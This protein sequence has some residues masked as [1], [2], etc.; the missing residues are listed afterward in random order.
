MVTNKQL[1]A[2][3]ENARKGGPKTVEGKAV[4]SRNAL[5]HGLTGRDL[6]IGNEKLA[7]VERFRKSFYDD[8]SPQGAVETMYVDI[9]WSS[10]WRYIMAVNAESNYLEARLDDNLFDSH[11]KPR[12]ASHIWEAVIIQE[13]QYNNPLALLH[14]YQTSYERRMYKALHEL[15]RLQAA[16]NGEKS[17]ATLAIDI[18]VSND[19]QPGPTAVQDSPL[20]LR[21]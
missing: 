17:P 11:N 19:D 4:V 8:L 3:R 9:I 18:D 13:V 15:E 12:L 21:S 14:R 7:D 1:I 6:L 5:K 16:R 10:A 20:L 2:N